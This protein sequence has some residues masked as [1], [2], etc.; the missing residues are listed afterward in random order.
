MVAMA[1]AG[2]GEEFERLVGDALG[3]LLAEDA[4]AFAVYEL[5]VQA[6]ASWLR[7]CVLDDTLD[8]TVV[9]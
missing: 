4:E 8:G 7:D 6:L 2:L 9:V 3:A 5:P 1:R